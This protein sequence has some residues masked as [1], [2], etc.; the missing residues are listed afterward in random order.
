M[1]TLTVLSFTCIVVLIIFTI[2]KPQNSS[3][4]LLQDNSKAEQSFVPNKTC[5]LAK[6]EREMMA[7]IKAKV[8]YLAAQSGTGKSHL[9]VTS[10]PKDKLF[11]SF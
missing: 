6:D 10:Q 7:N 3:K 2:G 8:D 9:N 11:T 5:S 4:N 1:F